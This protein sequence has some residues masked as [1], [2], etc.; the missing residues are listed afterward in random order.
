M[1][2][3]D[4]NVLSCFHEFLAGLLQQPTLQTLNNT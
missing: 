3:H 2:V 4:L 1:L